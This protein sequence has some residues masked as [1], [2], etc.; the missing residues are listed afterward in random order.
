MAGEYACNLFASRCTLNLLW[1]VLHRL[2]YAVAMV[3]SLARSLALYVICVVCSFSSI[4]IKLSL[5]IFDA[6]AFYATSAHYI[7]CW[8]AHTEG[9]RCNHMSSVLSDID[10]IIVSPYIST[11]PA[12]W[13]ELE[14]QCTRGFIKT[15]CRE[16]YNKNTSFAFF[17]QM[18]YTL[19][20]PFFSSSS[21]FWELE[22]D[23]KFVD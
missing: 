21:L 5:I 10:A 3:R 11:T 16:D 4:L 19:S 17:H 2:L 6:N 9:D 7:K 12:D 18:D 20:L 14:W 1:T 13:I 15:R 23:L 22:R 8:S